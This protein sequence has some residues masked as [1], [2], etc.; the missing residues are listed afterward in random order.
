MSALDVALIKKGAKNARADTEIL[1]YVEGF[2]NEF[3]RRAA[4]ADQVGPAFFELLGVVETDDLYTWAQADP[5]VREEALTRLREY[6]ATLGGPH[7]R[8][9][10]EW[11]DRRLAASAKD[12]TGRKEFLTRLT[13]FV[14]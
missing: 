13:A 5:A 4:T 14:T 10:K 1:S 7:Q 11:L 6:H 12:R 8:L 9:W 2:T 3:H